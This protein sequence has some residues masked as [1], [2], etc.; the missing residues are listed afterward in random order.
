MAWS[1]IT[2]ATPQSMLD[3]QPGLQPVLSGA[4]AELDNSAS[5][6]GAISS[7]LPHEANPLA[8][9]ASG[10][11]AYRAALTAL[12]SGGGRILAV[13]PYVHP[14]GDRRGDY[15]YL[16]ASDAIAHLAAKIAD[17][18]DAPRGA[19]L[20]GLA[21]LFRGVDNAGLAATMGAF[22][23]VFPLAELDM[24]M[25]RAGQ[26][27]GLDT[28]K[29]VQPT[30]PLHQRWRTSLPRR[31]MKATAMDIAL[32]G[33]IAIAEGYA[34]ESMRPEAELAA[35]IERKREHIAAR[36]AAWSDLVTT[37]Q[38]GSGLAMYATGSAAGLRTAFLA[39]TPP[40]QG[41]ALA[42]LICWVGTPEQLTFFKEFVGV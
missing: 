18:V 21:I 1:S 11:D 41:H 25:R 32:G 28:S 26:L 17:P 24:V 20:A 23:A 19:D 38:G 33:Q 37:L 22:N 2:I 4:G 39:S 16:T 8:A 10:A 14:V 31:N 5:R 9:S 12:L 30:G 34:A 29:L 42:A 40:E 6:L 7:L 15:A 35:L 27:A 36:T 3:A 13:H